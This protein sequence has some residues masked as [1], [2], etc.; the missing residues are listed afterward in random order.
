MNAKQ[1]NW[2][3]S[4]QMLLAAGLV[5]SC[6]ASAAELG[7]PVAFNAVSPDGL[8]E[9]RLDVGGKWMEYSI[10]RRGKAIVEPTPICLEIDGHWDLHDNGAQPKIVK[11]VKFGKTTEVSRGAV[12][13]GARCTPKVPTRKVDGTLATPLYKKSAINL[14]ANETRVDFGGWAVRLAARDDGVAWRF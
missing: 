9:L 6:L 12:L 7:S 2:P 10:W 14:A 5:A 4:R 1:I 13:N 8:N 11:L 3:R